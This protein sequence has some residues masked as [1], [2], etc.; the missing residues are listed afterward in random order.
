[1][2]T[3]A[4]QTSRAVAS[5][6]EGDE[7]HSTGLM[8]VGHSITGGVVS[9]MS[10]VLLHVAVFPQSSVAVYVLVTLDPRRHE[11]GIVTSVYVIPTKA[12]HASMAEG[13]PNDNDDPHSAGLLTTGQMITG[14]VLSCTTMVLLQAAVFPQSSIAIQ[15]LVTLYS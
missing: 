4:S 12:S 15:V 14:G 1:M 11:P 3:I 5:P 10:I 6:K 8:T 2:S 9:N 13:V 7:P